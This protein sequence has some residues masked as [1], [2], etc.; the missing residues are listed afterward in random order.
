M[1]KI[2][3]L[4]ILRTDKTVFTCKE[5]ML[6]VGETSLQQ[7]KRRINYYTTTGEFYHIRRGIYGKDQNYNR[8]ELATKIYTPS[9]I[10]FETVL[11]KA[12]VIFQYYSQIFVASYLSREI[13]CDKQTYVYKRIKP[14]II[15]NH[16]G[17]ENF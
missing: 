3:L 8:Y 14:V 17:I 4:D 7:L 6:F 11:V 1:K 9:Y 13:V 5:L 10:S 16:L 12:G 15:T 2:N